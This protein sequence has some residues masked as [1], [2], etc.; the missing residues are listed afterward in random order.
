MVA[1]VPASGCRF[2]LPQPVGD[3]VESQFKCDLK[4]CVIQSLAYHVLGILQDAELM[5]NMANIATAR[6][7]LATVLQTIFSEQRSGE[8]AVR[9]MRTL[10]ATG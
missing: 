8:I 4:A 5:L 3:E 2:C 10:E 1:M 6:A 7:R 9:L